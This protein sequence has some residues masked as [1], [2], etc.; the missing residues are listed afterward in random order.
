METN[1]SNPACRVRRSA[2]LLIA[3]EVMANLIA[4][5]WFEKRQATEER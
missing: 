2:A 1:W 4:R 5:G 3:D